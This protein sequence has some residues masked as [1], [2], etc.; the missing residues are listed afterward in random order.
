MHWTVGR[1]DGMTRRPDGWK[2]TEF[3]D[4][5]TV[6]NLLETLLNNGIPVEKHHYN[7]VILSNRMRPITNQQTPPLAILGQKS[8]DRL[9]IQSRSKNKNYSPFCHKG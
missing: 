1:P 7:E 4:F 6:H 2:G 8:L 9:K 3:Y 5:Q